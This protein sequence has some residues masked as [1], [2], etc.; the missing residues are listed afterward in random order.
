MIYKYQG[1]CDDKLF[2]QRAD[3][4]S[5]L[6]GGLFLTVEIYR[7]ITAFKDDA[8]L[9]GDQDIAGKLMSLFE[10]GEAGSQMLWQI[11]VGGGSVRY[12]WI[13]AVFSF[14]ACRANQHGGESNK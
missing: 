3:L 10:R 12:S 5:R 13:W 11:V 1:S 8:A 6:C 9:C 2:G 14:R 4:E 7:S